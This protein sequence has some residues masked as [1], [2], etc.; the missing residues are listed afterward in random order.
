MMAPMVLDG[1]MN[2]PAFVAYVQKR[3]ARLPA[4]P[5]VR[6]FVESDVTASQGRF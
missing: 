1:P 6:F 3:D 4:G 2:R 5:G